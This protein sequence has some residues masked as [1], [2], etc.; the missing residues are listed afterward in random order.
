MITK[1]FEEAYQRLNKAQKE[2]VDNPA[3]GPIMVIAGPGT[4]KTQIL[5]LRIA[6]ILLD[7]DIPA[8]GILALTFTEAG[9]KAMKLKLRKLIGSRADE[10]NI[11]TYHGFAASTIAEFPDHFPHLARARQMSDVETETLVREILRDKK[12]A[13]LRPLGE[14]DL[15]LSQIIKTISD[16]RKEAW[17]P[18]FIRN[19][20]KNEI[21][22]INSDPTFKSTRGAT[23]GLLKA[24]AE[25][26]IEKSKRTIIFADAYEQ[27]EISKRE[28]KKIDF[29]D[30]IF[31]LI[32]A[33]D[34]DN[35]LL[36]LLQEKYLYI[37]V[38]E[39]QD[40]N[41]SQNIL[42]KKIAN[43][44]QN[45]DNPNLFVVG[46]EKQAIYRFQGAS[47]QNFFEFQKFW[48][49]MKIVKLTDNY[50]S[51]QG[52]LDATFKMIENNYG[53]NEYNDLRIHL[54][55]ASEEKPE[56][57][58]V[59]LAGNNEAVE[60]YL[61]EQVK[62]VVE[63][64]QNE[65]VAIIVRTNREVERILEVLETVGVSASAERGTNVFSHP[66]GVIYFK[67]LEF[68]ADES[69]SESLGYTI[70]GGLWNLDLD[71]SAELLRRIRGGQNLE[72][73]K[74]LPK[75]VGLKKIISKTGPIEFLIVAAED[76]GLRNIVAGEPLSA[77]VWQSIVNLAKD[78][79][80][81]K[82]IEDP[83][84][85]ISEL[86]DYRQRSEKRNIKI[87]AGVTDEQVLIMTAHGSKGLEYDHVFLPYVTEESWMSRGR[88]QY[89]ILPESKNEGD[90]IKDAR[91][92]FYVALTRAK[93]HVSIIVGLADALDR[94]LSPLRFIDELDGEQVS[95][96]EIPKSKTSLV[97][98][99]TRSPEERDRIESLEYSK[100]VLLE[101]GLS[102]TALNHF[103]KCPSQFFY[104]SILKLPE[105]PSASSEKGNAMHEALSAVWSLQKKDRSS[106][107]ETITRVT[108]DYFRY[109][110]LPIY[111][112]EVI[113]EELRVN[114]PKV[115]E[116]LIDHFTQKGT[117][118]S[119]RW[120][121]TSFRGQFGDLP[122][123][124]RLHGKL[125]AIVTTPKQVFVYD[126][127]TKESMSEK[128]IKGETKS[129]DGSYFRQLIF[130]KML[131][132][133]NYLYQGKDILPALVF[134]KPDN[135]DRCPIV[136]LPIDKKDM[137]RVRDEIQALID[138]V[139]SGQI[140]TATCDDP[141]CE[142]CALRTMMK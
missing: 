109:S 67:L 2:A 134:V 119:E 54:N 80:L 5:T 29:D 138:S 137:E 130:Y 12:F 44:Q 35:L 9:Q 72:L 97:S 51:H 70:A 69:K 39:H 16:C 59:V 48:P 133:K 26:L 13:K 85:L 53:L 64:G 103:K 112:K 30:L 73:E 91:R 25:K 49:K 10:V 108:E 124:L 129:S 14:P 77:E 96:V 21:E 81:S 33:F 110:L 1:E 123:E 106:I 135:K 104:K 93:K 78:L 136:S 82:N 45:E 50:R 114:A 68:L 113:I 19:Y 6:K 92:L 15:Y 66:V 121:E 99:R 18:E 132:T 101:K 105:A 20:A 7:S 120:E 57:V 89:F 40:T 60:E 71:K 3:D 142:F 4:G 100:H 17:D 46:D 126:Y 102:V 111:E 62:K 52:V 116:A 118:V 117:I 47:V 22:R 55:A 98:A 27:Y 90:E 76:S 83:R 11:F 140:L 42:I 74:N 31:E 128:E 28:Q 38:D 87:A 65:T 95:H 115:V 36:R 56:P 94:P 122:V 32:K 34:D 131:L 84:L 86:L 88:G 41:N 8:S 125:D 24:E 37:L 141:K 127:K 107:T 43:S 61:A 139:W 75:L 23:K 63:T 58:E 79:A